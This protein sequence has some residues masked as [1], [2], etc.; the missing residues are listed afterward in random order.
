VVDREELHEGKHRLD[1]PRVETDLVRV[2][3][4]LQLLD[5]LVDEREDDWG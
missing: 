1:E 2:V 5:E 4:D 3:R